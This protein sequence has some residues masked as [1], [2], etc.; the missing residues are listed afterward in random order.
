MNGSENK[1]LKDLTDEELILHFQKTDDIEA[2]NILVARYKD[3]LMNFI[4][5]FLGNRDLC[6]DVLQ[7]TF[8]RLY[9]NK[10]YYT[11]IAKFSTWIYTIAANLAKTEL[12]KKNRR[13]FF[14]IQGTNLHGNDEVTEFELPDET[15]RP[16]EY[17]DS[18]IKN[19]I[20]LNALK[21]VKP[22]YR[23]LII[24]RDIQELSYEEIAEVTGLN[25]GT[26]KSRI[27]RGRTR[28]Q[29]LL[30]HIYHV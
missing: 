24:L 8:F 16:D 30:K 11:T 18:V 27:N 23:E 5:K 10:N 20:I 4:F 26:V 21:K 22:L 6:E 29:K 12:R 25:I 13:V 17:A 28:L 7:E 19:K 14:S 15:Y 3:P 9:K 2:Y 1:K